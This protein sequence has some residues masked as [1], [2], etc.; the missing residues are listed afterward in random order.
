MHFSKSVYK[1]F[2]KKYSE[3]QQQNISLFASPH[4]LNN[5]HVFQENKI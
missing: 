2:R 4:I 1:N 5:C 3:I